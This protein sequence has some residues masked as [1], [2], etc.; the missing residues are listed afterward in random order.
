M[1]TEAG[2]WEARSNWAD[3][4]SHSFCPKC[5]SGAVMVAYGVYE[6]NTFGWRFLCGGCGDA[7]PCEI[8]ESLSKQM[9]REAN[10]GV[11][12]HPH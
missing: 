5:G 8:R 4:G 11:H 6:D 10:D 12:E 3:T 2:E 1:Q 9:A 7:G